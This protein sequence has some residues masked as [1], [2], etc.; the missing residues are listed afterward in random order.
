MNLMDDSLWLSVCS[1]LLWVILLSVSMVLSCG[2]WVKCLVR[3]GWQ[4]LVLVLMGLFFGGMQ[5]MVLV[6]I[7]FLSVR[8]LLVC[9]VY[10]LVENLNLLI[11]LQSRLLVQLLV[12]G[13]LVWLVLCSFGV[14]LMMRKCVLFW[15]KDGMGVLNQFGYSVVF[16]WWKVSRC[17]QRL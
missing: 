14:R 11:V 3:K 12:K 4:V 9:E 17:G 10:L 15:L 7:V 1:V 16:F 2:S 13:W 8:L 5:C 6:I